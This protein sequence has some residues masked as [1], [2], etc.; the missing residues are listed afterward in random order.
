MS[1]SNS[2]PSGFSDISMAGD[3][4][5]PMNLRSTL[6]MAALPKSVRGVGKLWRKQGQ[7]PWRISESLSPVALF[8]S[9]GI[10]RSSPIALYIARQSARRPET[11]P[12]SRQGKAGLPGVQN[13]TVSACCS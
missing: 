13:S 11:Q 5:S 12:G 10:D 4:R 2:I 1:P 9:A 6:L 8:C 7:T 3:S